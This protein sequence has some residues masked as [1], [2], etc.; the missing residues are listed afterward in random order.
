VPVANEGLIVKKVTPNVD[1]TNLQHTEEVRAL[2]VEELNVIG[3]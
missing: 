2:E 3:A 1:T